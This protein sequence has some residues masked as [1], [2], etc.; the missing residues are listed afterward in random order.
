V[1]ES[2][3]VAAQVSDYMVVSENF[4]DIFEREVKDA[5]A[6]GWRPQGGISVITWETGTGYYQAM[7]K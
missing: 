4:V 1:G 2:S 6:A 5:I 7:V 3:K